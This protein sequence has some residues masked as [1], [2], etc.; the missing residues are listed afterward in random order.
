MIDRND[1]RKKAE[2]ARDEA[3]K[4]VLFIGDIAYERGSH[5]VME[6]FREAASPPVVLELLAELADKQ[7]QLDSSLAFLDKHEYGQKVTLIEQQR[8]ALAIAAETLDGIW[9]WCSKRGDGVDNYPANPLSH[10]DA[11]PYR[12]ASDALIRIGAI[13]KGEQK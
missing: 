1:L 13:M 9:C 11:C 5:V 3:E 6:A 7:E 10:D 4:G 12:V 8:Q 2:A